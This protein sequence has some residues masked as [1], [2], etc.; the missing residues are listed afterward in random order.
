MYEGF[1]Y[2]QILFFNLSQHTV[3][4]NGLAWYI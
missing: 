2:A 1:S 4:K 3:F